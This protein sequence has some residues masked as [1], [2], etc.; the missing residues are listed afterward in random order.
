VLSLLEASLTVA[1]EDFTCIK[2]NE[3]FVRVHTQE[4]C[5]TLCKAKDT[6]VGYRVRFPKKNDPKCYTYDHG[7]STDSEMCMKSTKILEMV[8]TDDSDFERDRRAKVKEGKNTKIKCETYCKNRRNCDGYI[9]DSNDASCRALQPKRILRE[10]ARKKEDVS[11]VI[12]KFEDAF[13][14]CFNKN[15]LDITVLTMNT[16]TEVTATSDTCSCD[17]IDD[18]LK[19]NYKPIGATYYQPE[20]YGTHGS[21]LSS[22]YSCSQGD[23]HHL[24]EDGEE[25]N[26]C[27]TLIYNACTCWN[28][29]E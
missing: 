28:T 25:F 29:S 24:F 2:I 12:S 4:H 1:G 6:C 27:T 21:P 11:L 7:D 23:A 15:D 19:L 9:Y 22:Q 16:D 14:R 5:D 10:R 17:S 8:S 13:C 18:G 26:R 20:G 3:D